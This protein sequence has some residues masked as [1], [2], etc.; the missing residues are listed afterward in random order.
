MEMM[1][2]L[3]EKGSKVISLEFIKAI[4]ILRVKVQEEEERKEGYMAMYGGDLQLEGRS[5]G[6]EG[7]FL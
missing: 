7:N 4:L 2:R 6:L 5:A 1:R 3:E